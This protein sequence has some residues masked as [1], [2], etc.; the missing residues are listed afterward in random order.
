METQ[1]TVTVTEDGKMIFTKDTEIVEKEHDRLV[2]MLNEHLDMTMGDA[3]I[4][5]QWLKNTC[6]NIYA[7]ECMRDFLNRRRRN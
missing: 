4:Y 7:K 2:I 3:E 5:A 6:T 1:Y